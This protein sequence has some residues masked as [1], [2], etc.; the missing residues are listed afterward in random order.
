MRVSVSLWSAGALAALAFAAPAHAD[1]KVWEAGVTSAG[2]PRLA[3]VDIDSADS[4]QVFRCPN[5]ADCEPLP[6]A[7]VGSVFGRPVDLSTAAPGDVFEARFTQSGSVVQTDRTPPWLGTYVVTRRPA[8]IGKLA[9]GAVVTG[10]AGTWSG[11]WDRPWRQEASSRIVACQRPDGIDCVEFSP[12]YPNV[13]LTS[14][15]A[16][17]Y[18]FAISQI[19][20]G[21]A[22]D[23][24]VTDYAYPPY[25]NPIAPIG[26]VAGTRAVSAAFGPVAAAPTPTPTPAPRPTASI[27][28]KALRAKGQL[29]VARVTCPTSCTVNLTVSSAGRKTLHRTLRVTGTKALT[30]PPRHGKLKVRIVVGGKTLASGNS[31]AR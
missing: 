27:R 6:F 19:G 3:V 25:P 5:G 8:V 13:L 11:G 4:V 12:F 23:N 16:G 30:I 15:Q 24:T 2:G 26:V 17:W 21:H 20:S 10:D 18:V 7:G 22:N 9:E 14:R 29:S 28:A 31:R 1:D